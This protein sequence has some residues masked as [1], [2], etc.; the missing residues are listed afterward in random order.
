MTN[1]PKIEDGLTCLLPPVQQLANECACATATPN[2][3][4][5]GKIYCTPESGAL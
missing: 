4:F 1:L 5:L 3:I 2:G